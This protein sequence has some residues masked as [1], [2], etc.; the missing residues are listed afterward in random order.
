M[1]SINGTVVP[2][3]MAKTLRFT[4]CSFAPD[5]SH[6]SGSY[7]FA[8]FIAGE[9][10]AALVGINLSAYGL[11]STEPLTRHIFTRTVGVV[12]KRADEACQNPDVHSGFD[13]LDAIVASNM[14]SFWYCPIQEKH[15][16]KDTVQAALEIF[17]S[18]IGKKLSELQTQPQKRIN[19]RWCE[20]PTNKFKVS[21]MRLALTSC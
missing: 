20:S 4:I 10:D 19:E 12:A 3:P 14:S 6:S 8:V 17:A 18:A 11:K 15:T 2:N 7:D 13:I 9:N 16:E 21:E 5:P 1:L